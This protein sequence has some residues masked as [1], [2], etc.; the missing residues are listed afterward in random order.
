MPRVYS[1]RKGAETPPVGAVYVG[2]PSRWGNPFKLEKESDRQLVIEQFRE[3]A[4]ERV[5]REPD[6]LKPLRGKDL[7]FWC[8]PKAC[9]ADLLLELANR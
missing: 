5:E 3:Y 7:V 1:R 8:A 2:R 9:H 6:W 4:T